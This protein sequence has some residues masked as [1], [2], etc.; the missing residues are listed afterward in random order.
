MEALCQI[1]RWL[2]KASVSSRSS[3]ELKKKKDDGAGMVRGGG[4]VNPIGRFRSTKR[5]EV[6]L[7]PHLFPS[8]NKI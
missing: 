4:S 1:I 3:K 7:K 5:E 8:L 6:D 2:I